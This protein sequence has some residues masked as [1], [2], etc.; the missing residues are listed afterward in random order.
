M[1]Y[2][3]DVAK[4]SVFDPERAGHLS[5]NQQGDLPTHFR[6]DAGGSLVHSFTHIISA[7]SPT[8]D[9]IAPPSFLGDCPLKTGQEKRQQHAL[10][11][12][13]LVIYLHELEAGTVGPV[14]HHRGDEGLDVFLGYA[15]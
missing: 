7:P 6:L 11:R 9:D 8:G 2:E 4:E 10:E 12:V 3:E 14:L 1:V 15:C 5:S 13:I